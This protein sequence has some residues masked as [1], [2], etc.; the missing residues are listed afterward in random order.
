LRSG[1]GQS[2]HH[3]RRDQ[4]GSQSKGMLQRDIKGGITQG[5]VSQQ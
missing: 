2:H 1:T 5:A 4:A 3:V